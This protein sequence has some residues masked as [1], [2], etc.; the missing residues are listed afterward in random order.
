MTKKINYARMTFK[1]TFGKY[2][3]GEKINPNTGLPQKA[4]KKEYVLWAGIWSLTQEQRVSLAGIG[5]ENATV[6]FIRHNSKITSD[7]TVFKGD[8]E[9]TIKSIAYDNGFSSQGYDLLT[10]ERK[11]TDHA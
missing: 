10:C 5:I 4:F 7:Y 8:E 1:L 6:F 11:V 2:G 3:D 9:Y